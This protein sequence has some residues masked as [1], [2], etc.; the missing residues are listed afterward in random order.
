MQ[1]EFL[2]FRRDL[3]GG[4]VVAITVADFHGDGV[5]GRLVVERRADHTRR[6][7]GEPPIVA[8]AFGAT[9]EEVLRRLREIAESDNELAMRLD[10]W[11]AGYRRQ[12]I[13]GPPRGLQ[14]MR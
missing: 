10:L 14:K 7:K 11:N 4:R 3:P 13:T 1:S 12:R 6:S 2:A 5:I 9:R 8:E